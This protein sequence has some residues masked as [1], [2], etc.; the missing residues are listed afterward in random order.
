MK[1]CSLVLLATALFLGGCANSL[2]IQK[3]VETNVER[4]LKSYNLDIMTSEG[5]SVVNSPRLQ[6]SVQGAKT[7]TVKSFEHQVAYDVFTPYQGLRELYEI[8]V[9][10]AT[11]PVAVTVNMV[12]FLLLGLLPNSFTDTLLDVSFAGLNPFLNIES[13]SRFKKEVLSE[14]KKLL[15]E[16]EEFVKKPLAGGT[17]TI[18][19]GTAKTTH[20]LDANGKAEIPLLPIGSAL[21]EGAEHLLLEAESEG[22]KATL[23]LDIGRQLEARIKQA[24]AI[25][26]KYGSALSA[27]ASGD[28]GAVPDIKAMATD[29]AA[30]SRLGFEKESK[31]LEKML[32]QTLKDSDQGELRKEIVNALL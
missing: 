6:V 27:A 9:G 15:D 30:L 14:E 32:L 20:T 4:E 7:F 16:K 25:T 1:D 17:L 28:N 13:E 24:A 26:G 2:P 23:Q 12:D 10:I 22:T 19:A 21:T 31:G 29:I 8:P 5:S 11:L 18:A 3:T